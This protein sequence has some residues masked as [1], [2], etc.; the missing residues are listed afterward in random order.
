[1]TLP[2]LYPLKS[3]KI[4]STNSIQSVTIDKYKIVVDSDGDTRLTYGYTGS[5]Y[6]MYEFF[7]ERELFETPELAAERK[8]A[9][10][11]IRFNLD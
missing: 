9:L 7:E 8:E 6:G 10:R 11:R 1:M 5:W 2:I 4:H 3:V